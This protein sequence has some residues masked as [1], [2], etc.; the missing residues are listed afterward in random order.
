MDLS[1]Y[2]EVLTALCTCFMA[3]L[4]WL[5]TTLSPYIFFLLFLMF[6]FWGYIDSKIE[7]VYMCEILFR[8]NLS[9]FKPILGC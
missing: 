7:I 6:I 9:S 4:S 5:S 3:F 8:S 1:T 2:S